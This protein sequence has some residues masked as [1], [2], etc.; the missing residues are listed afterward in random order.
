MNAIPTPSDSG[1]RDGR[2][3]FG[4]RHLQVVPELG[5][6]LSRLS[7][8][9]RARVTGVYARFVKPI[10]DRAIAAVALAV[11]AVPLGSIAL[12]IHI[13]MGGPVL[14]RQERVGLGGTP[15]TVLKFRTMH[16]D[17][18]KIAV[19]VEL[20][21]RQTH[22][23][24]ADPRHTRLGRFLRK[25]GIDELPQLI[26]VVRGQMGIVGPRPELCDVVSRYDDPSLHDRHLVRPGLT[27][28]WQISARGDGLM[29]ENAEWDLA[30][31]D[32]MSLRRDI[33]IVVQTPF[34]M[35][36]GHTGE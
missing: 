24:A 27:G 20:D 12:M 14:F 1:D 17:R 6:D 30:Y 7:P 33:S 2:P 8:E 4:R 35:L 3:D 21:R 25:W 9:T 28:L 26:N 10:A 18:R 15:F 16:H 13:T 22:K 23:S 32:Q 5:P 36:N 11:L 31:L 34:A 29:H 19:P